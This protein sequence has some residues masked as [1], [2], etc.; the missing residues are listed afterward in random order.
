MAFKAVEHIKLFK[1]KSNYCVSLDS[2][3][4]VGRINDQQPHTVIQMKMFQ[5]SLLS[6]K[7]K[8]SVLNLTSSTAKT[9]MLIMNL[10]LSL[11]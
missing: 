3:K 8:A 4:S 7:I 10:Y 2:E 1:V 5:L 11:I 9:K 6:F